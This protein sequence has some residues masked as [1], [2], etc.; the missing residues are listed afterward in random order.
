MFK[1]F[2]RQLLFFSGII[3][4]AT[5]ILSFLLPHGYISPALPF[6]IPLFVI[7]SAGS[8][9]LLFSASGK[10][11][12]KFVNAFLLTI[13]IK[14]FLYLIIMVTYALLNRQDA[15]PFLVSFFILYLLYT[16]FETIFIVG[17]NTP[18]KATS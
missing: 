15:V 16:V 9:Y 6:L 2:I 7:T 18:G 12:I 5:A 17:G 3:A 10:R 13:V 4:I 8:F 1:K 11:F 14:L